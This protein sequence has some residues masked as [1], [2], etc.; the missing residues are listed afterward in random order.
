MVPRGRYRATAGREGV[1]RLFLCATVLILAGGMTTASSGGPVVNVTEVDGIYNVHAVFPV[2][3][4]PRDAVAVLTD[5][6]RIPEFMPDVRTSEVIERTANGL[7]VEQLATSKFLMFSKTV[8]L[9]LEVSEQDGEI[10]FRDRS[11]QSFTAYQ[12]AWIVV[13]HG[14]GAMITYHLMAK[15]AFDVPGFVLKRLLKRD[16][17]LLIDRLKAEIAARADRRQ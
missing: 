4:A 14:S 1:R 12:G 15:P 2:A 16:A 5:Y 7:V 6:P 13:P 9:V 8:H 10:R 11:G 3:Q 17:A